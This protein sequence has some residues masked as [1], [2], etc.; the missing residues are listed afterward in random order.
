MHTFL[1]FFSWPDG[2]AWSNVAAMPL[3]GV[4]AVVFAVFFRKPAAR[5][6]GRHFGMH[7]DLAE[8]RELAARAHRI[9]ADTHHRI[10]GEH[11]P[12]APEVRNE[13]EAR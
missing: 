8:I 4:V 7:A 9:A 11:H 2:G 1:L 13:T 5:W 12:D 6:W 3:C 10:T